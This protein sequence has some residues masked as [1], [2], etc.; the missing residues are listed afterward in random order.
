[1]TCT[2]LCLINASGTHT[3]PR[4]TRPN[5]PVRWDVSVTLTLPRGEKNIHAFTVPC[6]FMFDLVPAVNE[7]VNEL[8]S[9]HGDQVRSASWIA[10]GRGAVKKRKK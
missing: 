8:I 6:A 7:R 4:G 10:H 1:M 2:V 3:T 5:K 9:D